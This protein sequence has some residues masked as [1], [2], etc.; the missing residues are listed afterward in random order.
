M[1]EEKPYDQ[2]SDMWAFG[3]VLYELCT[4]KHPFDANNQGA[5]I[6]RIIKGKYT[7][8]PST[9]SKELSDVVDLCLNRSMQKRCSASAIL[10]MP[11]TINILLF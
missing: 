4:Q 9:Y 6:L 11:C 10:A 3:C 8:I 2:K 5:L 1:C 7:P